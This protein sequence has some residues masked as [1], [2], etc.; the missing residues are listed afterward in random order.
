[1]GEK[2]W[3]LEGK[4]VDESNPMEVFKAKI[5]FLIQESRDFDS[6]EIDRM[7]QLIKEVEKG[8]T[9][10]EDALAEAQA[11]KDAKQDYH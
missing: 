10:I 3:N 11:L 4:R 6:G 9:S 2:N 5:G 1:M 8:E 7:K